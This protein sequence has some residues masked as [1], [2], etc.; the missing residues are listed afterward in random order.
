M[1]K[2]LYK[3]ALEVFANPF[4]E[5][6]VAPVTNGL[7]N[8]SFKVTS[9]NTG[10]SFLLQQINHHV[11]KEPWKLQHNYGLLWKHLENEDIAFAIPEPK[12][13]PGDTSMYCD[14]NGNYWRVF[15]F[16]DGTSTWHVA[17][18]AAQAQTVAET[19][20]QLTASFQDFDA[21]ELFITIQGFHDLSARFK[22][23]TQSMESST[24]E[25]KQECS[26]LI[27][28]LIE[29]EKYTALYDVLISSDAF[30]LRVMHHDAKISNILFD[31]KT[32]EVVCP[33]DF[34]TVMP[35]YIFS[36]VGDM[37]RSM[38]CKENE[39]S[40]G[41]EK[42]S[43]RKDFY[44]AIINGY[45][46]TIGHLLT[47]A[48]KKYIHFSGLMMVYM[49]SLRFVTDHLNGDVYY[50]TTY[51]GQNADRA[52]N[53]LALLEKLEQFLLENYQFSV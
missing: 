37:I 50:Q 4:H 35:G 6:K 22:Q 1:K 7:I 18:N 34:D 38:V 2:A 32:G 43:I 23:F 10:R 25:K 27:N 14:S 29:R 24:Q 49:Q 5:F 11:F 28:A 46:E 20:G 42:I 17:E 15:D 33:V 48:E 12:L 3:E 13:F 21:D 52:G 36:D 53:Q 30:R 41:H 31:E 19:F 40:T 47:D 9:K 44:E 8:Q 51:P 26:S 45:M 16:I 39:D